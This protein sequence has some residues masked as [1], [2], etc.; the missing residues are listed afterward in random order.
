MLT[1]G[2][3]API[4][5]KTGAKKGLWKSWQTVEGRTRRQP[6]A[7]GFIYLRSKSSLLEKKHINMSCGSLIR[8]E[9]L[10]WGEEGSTKLSYAGLCSGVNARGRRK[11]GRTGKLRKKTSIT[12]LEGLDYT[13]DRARKPASKN[14]PSARN[15]SDRE[16][17]GL[18]PKRVHPGGGLLTGKGQGPSRMR[19][20]GL[21]ERSQ[22]KGKLW[23][24]GRFVLERGDKSFSKK[25]RKKSRGIIGGKGKVRKKWASL[26]GSYK[27][28]R[29]AKAREGGN[30]TGP[31]RRK[32]E[33]RRQ[34]RSST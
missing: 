25:K 19:K 8:A 9:I 5:A 12:D 26:Q 15:V 13:K 14:A 29:S 1:N 4:F 16:K 27:S 30:G 11:E 31:V 21:R 2:Q 23:A 22:Q 20:E 28:S 32:R 33:C 3:N 7:S 17:K 34:K 24:R 10:L 6:K 18:V